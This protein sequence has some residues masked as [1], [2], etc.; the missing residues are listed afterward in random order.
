MEDIVKVDG[1]E[2]CTQIDCTMKDCVH[3]PKN[4]P[5]GFETLRARNMRRECRN[6]R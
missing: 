3:H 2:Y 1:M 6:G 5:E 4:I